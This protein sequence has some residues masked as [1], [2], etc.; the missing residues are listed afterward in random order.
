MFSCGHCQCAL[1]SIEEIIANR[2]AEKHYCFYGSSNVNLDY[3][4][5]QM[6]KGADDEQVSTTKL[7]QKIPAPAPPLPLGHS[8]QQ[9]VWKEDEVLLLIS[10][11]KNHKEKFNSGN[12]NKKNVWIIISNEMKTHGVNKDS[13]KCDEK[14]RN[15]RKV[16]DKVK[17]EN[18][19]TGNGNTNWKYF[20]DFQDIYHKDPR[21]TPVCTATSSGV[22]RP[23]TSKEN[24]PAKK[25]KFSP[26]EVKR[27]KSI[28]LKDLDARIQK[29]HEEKM[30]FKNKVFEWFKNNYKK[31]E[32]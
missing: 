11:Y 14:W 30:D 12:I 22:I 9:N 24:M 29:R 10:T 21:F 15:L 3:T 28:S 18:E 32:D 7:V 27:P 20:K 31:R 16:Y 19:K 6:F 2:L 4:S 1:G 25:S 23:S 8:T 5:H 17:M 13:V 26:E